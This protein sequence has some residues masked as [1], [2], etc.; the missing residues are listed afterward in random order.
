MFCGPP[1]PAARRVVAPLVDAPLPARARVVLPLPPLGLA[2]PAFG[3]RAPD[4]TLVEEA[5]CTILIFQLF[6]VSKCMGK[7]VKRLILF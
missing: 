6:F 3:E 4:P 2:A 7:D 5:A 1:E